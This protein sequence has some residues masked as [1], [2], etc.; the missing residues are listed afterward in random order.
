MKRMSLALVLTAIFFSSGISSAQAHGELVSSYPK[1]NESLNQLPAYV[2][3]VFDG[4][5]LSLGKAKV[6]VLEV[7]DASGARLDDG[8]SIT[9]GAKLKVNLLQLNTTGVV[10]V[11]WRITSEDGHPVEGG[12]SFS[13]GSVETSTPLTNATI[14]AEHQKSFFNQYRLFIYLLLVAICLAGIFVA[15]RAREKGPK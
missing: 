12:Y 2:E 5:L 13:V 15:R 3:L 1:V 8:K 14:P 9:T 10:S 6:N 7:R 4:N 11:T